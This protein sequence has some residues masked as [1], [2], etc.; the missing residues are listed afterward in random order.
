MNRRNNLLI[1]LLLAMAISQPCPLL[2]HHQT[3]E[4]STTKAG[5]KRPSGR[6]K[7]PPRT[8]PDHQTEALEP[9]SVPEI[10]LTKRVILKAVVIDADTGE[11][12]PHRVHISDGEGI[13]YPP[14]GHKDISTIRWH[15]NNVSYEPDTSND[16]Y[17]WAMIPGGRFQVALP[18]RN[19]VRVRISHGLEYPLKTFALNLSDKAGATLERTFSLQRGINMRERGWMAAD[20]HVH[21]LTPLG[22]IRQMPVEAVDYVNLM[23]IGPG[24]SLLRRTPPTDKASPLSTKDH[25]VAVSQ[26]VR[27]ANQGHMT[28][29]GM[30]Q[31]ITPIRAFTG[32]SKLPQ[33]APLPNEPLNWE[34]F[35]RL[36]AQD[37]LAFHAH[38]LYWPG[39]GSAVG[40]ALQKLDGVEWLRSD[41]VSR[42]DRTRHN[43]SVPVFGR[44][45]AGYM[46]YDM[47]NCGVRLPLIGGTDKMGANRVV[48]GS[49]RTY[50][51]VDSWSHKGFLKGLR[52]KETFVTNGPLLDLAANDQ[53]IGTELK[54]SG[55]GPFQVRLKAG[56]F[57][58]RPIKFLE[59]IVNG[60]VVQSVN[61]SKD[62]KSAKILKEIEFRKSG[63][64]AL[65]ARHDQPNSDSWH[66]GVTAAHS[67]PIYVTVNKKLPAI[68]ES[69]RYLV[70]RLDTTLQ[71]AEKE[72]IWSDENY[73]KKAITSFQQARRFYQSALDRAR[74]AA[75]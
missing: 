30:S 23:F 51:K 7:L 54:F 20:T 22:A 18:D 15:S 33:L 27:D 63:W 35:D 50:V 66:S 39:H 56:C 59:L 16:G 1:A 25:I 55:K 2:A 69:A 24:H 41:F 11:V 60:E 3:P 37:G 29:M 4:R 52:R 75:P 28:L 74:S 12:L 38:Y 8:A 6:P 17:N 45:A 67:S 71:W 70:G 65:R 58:Q 61:L 47:L 14:E 36:H 48:G 31:P 19:E 5:T 32:T 64:V 13:Y 62:Q 40:A 9:G 46:W 26:E 72:A 73:R 57:T 34:V 10:P 68:A 43:I 44:R 53:P 21:N 42:N 49:C